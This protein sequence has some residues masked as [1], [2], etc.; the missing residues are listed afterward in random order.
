MAAL[1]LIR[2]DQ[3]L[4]HGQIIVKWSAVAKANKIIVVDDRVAGDDM[5]KG[6]FKMAAPPGVKVLCYSQ[7]RA[8]AKW[9]EKQFGEGNAMVMFK[10]IGNAYKAFKAGFPISKL[11]LGNAPKGEGKKALH[12]EVYASEEEV[13]MLKEMQQ[14]GVEITIHTIPEQ[15]S[16]SLDKALANY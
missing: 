1:T 6:V 13:A 11:Q 9:N 14:A 10:T 15:A 8:L 12:N 5:M 7:E 16:I 4:V 3:R 2:V